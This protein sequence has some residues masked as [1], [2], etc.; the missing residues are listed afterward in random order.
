MRVTTLL[1]LLVIATLLVTVVAP[2]EEAACSSTCCE[3]LAPAQ[4][5]AATTQPCPAAPPT[6]LVAPAPSA[7]SLGCG[8]GP[9][10]PPVAAPVVPPDHAVA[11]LRV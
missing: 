2:C 1:S 10:V 11:R 5:L 8:D 9:C 6:E 7:A 3:E 4:P